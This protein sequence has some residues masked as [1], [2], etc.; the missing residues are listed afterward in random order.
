MERWRAALRL[1]GDDGGG[2]RWRYA[3]FELDPS[4]P[5]EGVDPRASLEAKYGPGAAEALGRR[6]ADVAAAEGLPMAG[7]ATMKVRPNTL[8]AHRLLTAALEQGETYQQALANELFA[9][10]WG[11]GEDVGDAAVLD[12]AAAAAGLGA[13][14][15]G[16]ILAGDAWSAEVRAEERRA[17]E[18]GIH[19]VPT[20]VFGERTGLSGAQPPAALAEAVRRAAGRG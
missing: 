10:Y 2:V 17:A 14:W 5:A 13:G 11:R 15:A 3:A 7:L 16:A 12:A 1:L 19:A 6:L 8:A 9:A 20:F 18:L 4:I